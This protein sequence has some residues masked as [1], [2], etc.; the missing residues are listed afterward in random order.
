M[1]TNSRSS[2]ASKSWIKWR[3][4]L[5]PSFSAGLLLCLGSWGGSAARLS[6]ALAEPKVPNAARRITDSDY[7]SLQTAIDAI[8]ITGG[9]VEVSRVHELREEITLRSDVQLLGMGGR[10]IFR[11]DRPFV[12]EGDAT[13]SRVAINA[14]HVQNVRLFDLEVSDGAPQAGPLVGIRLFDSVD[15][16]VERNRLNKASMVFH[17][18]DTRKVRNLRCRDNVLELGGIDASGINVS[19]QNGALIDGNTIDAGREGIGIYNGTQNSVISRNHTT[20]HRP[21]DGIVVIAGHDLIIS[22]NISRDNAQS[23]IATQRFH[24]GNDVRHVIIVSNLVAGNAFDGIDANG[25]LVATKDRVPYD[26]SIVGNQSHD[27]ERSGLYLTHASY[28]LVVANQATSNGLA[29]VHVHESGHVL[30]S[31]NLTSENSSKEE[32]RKLKAGFVFYDAP[33]ATSTGNVSMNA[34]TDNQLWGLVDVNDGRRSA[35]VTISGGYYGDNTQGT[36]S[37]TPLDVIRANG[38]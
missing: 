21:G 12:H 8:A 35:S 37:R 24:E 26:I 4:V 7:G 23:G 22:E 16:W 3:W 31:S 5:A 32:N 17:S 34:R 2:S 28:A 27:N 36:V 20:N 13:P 25:G 1:A 30:T 19:A 15:S 38:R 29:G 6:I 9:T 11:G 33:H 10:I 14:S 18:V